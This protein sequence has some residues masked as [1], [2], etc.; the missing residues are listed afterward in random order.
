[1]GNKRCRGVLRGVSVSAEATNRTIRREG[2]GG[3]VSI[4]AASRSFPA[5][6]IEQLKIFNQPILLSLKFSA[7]C[8]SHFL[9]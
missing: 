9:S 6:A 1:M 4:D 8:S 5:H 7:I 2:T 3:C